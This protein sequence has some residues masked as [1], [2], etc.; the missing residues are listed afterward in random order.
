MKEP[1]PVSIPQGKMRRYV[2]DGDISSIEIHVYSSGH[3]FLHVGE[4]CICLTRDQTCE[5]LK[6]AYGSWVRR[7]Y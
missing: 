3:C 2:Y 5:L 1:P 6:D 7:A 4:A